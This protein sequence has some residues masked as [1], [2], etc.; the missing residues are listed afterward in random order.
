T[1]LRRAKER[2]A[3]LREILRREVLGDVGSFPQQLRAD[4]EFVGWAWKW[5]RLGRDETQGALKFT[6]MHLVEA[7]LTDRRLPE[8]EFW[9]D[10]DS[11][12]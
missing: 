3:A 10:A 9:Q 4:F 1:N 11:L 8:R 6:P 2:L 5:P 12:L 7:I